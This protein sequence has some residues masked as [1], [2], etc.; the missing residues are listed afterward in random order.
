VKGA[1]EMIAKLQAIAKELPLRLASAMYVEAQ[2]EMTE[3]K[4]RCPVAPG[5]GTL[6]ASGFV[7][8]PEITNRLITVTLSYGGA[9]DAYALAVHEHLSSH[10]P[11]SWQRAESEGSGVHWSTAGTGP[12]FL[13]SVLNESQ[14]TMAERL[15]Q[16]LQLG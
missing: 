3:S 6:R 7:T 12:K 14:A 13:E 16:R 15:A 1:P 11:Y 4:K 2:I 8:R 10:S 5:G 9:A